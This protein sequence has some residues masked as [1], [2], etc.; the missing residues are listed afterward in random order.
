[1]ITSTLGRA[2]AKSSS[3][4]RLIDPHGLRAM[5]LSYGPTHLRKMVKEGLFPAPIRLSA[6]KLAWR[7]ADIIAWVEAKAQTDRSSKSGRSAK[8]RT[9]RR[10]KA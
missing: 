4:L 5:G 8:P 3:E 2:R 6:R 7:E 1:M 9:A 10:S